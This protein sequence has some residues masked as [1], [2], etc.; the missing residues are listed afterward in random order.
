[1][2]R[3]HR[4]VWL[5]VCCM[6]LAAGCV[7]AEST[8][9]G[10]SMDTVTAITVYKKEDEEAAQTA[11]HKLEEWE[12]QW[13]ADRTDGLIYQINHGQGQTVSRDTM[14]MLKL[15]QT[16]ETQTQGAYTLAIRPL[17]ELWHINERTSEEP[18]PEQARIEQAKSFC[19]QANLSI[20]PQ[21]DGTGYV[22]T[23]EGAGL[24]LGSV[25]KGKAAEL[26]KAYLQSQ[27]VE[28]ALIDL[29]GNVCAVGERTY[30]IG[31]QDPRN[32]QSLLAV[33]KVRG[34]SV[35]T[36]GDYQ[37]YVEIDHTRYPH[38][39]DARTGRPASSGL[40]SVTIVGE[41]SMVCDALSTAVFLVGEQEGLKLVEAYGAEAV[42]VNQERQVIVTDG[43]KDSFTLQGRDY[44][45]K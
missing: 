16:L 34:K 3:M 11:L 37:R 45:L 43:L 24:D 2:K 36:S 1:M 25:A 9:R 7:P 19:G 20:R 5:G 6:L 14:E 27:G 29:G 15:G 38:I 4:A 39:L 31:I 40:I 18:L 12:T 44:T 30:E 21:E 8:V 41:D 35:V 26:L 23:R 10:F 32:E 17:V 22:E 13:S 42:L 28:N 33:L